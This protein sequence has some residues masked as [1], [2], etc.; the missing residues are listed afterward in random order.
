MLASAVL[1]HSK[2]LETQLMEYA[3]SSEFSTYQSDAAM[4]ESILMKI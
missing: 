1:S 3:E 4:L 2:T